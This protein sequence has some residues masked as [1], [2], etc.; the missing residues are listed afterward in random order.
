MTIYVFEEDSMEKRYES[1]MTRKEKRQN[2]LKKLKSMTF[3]QKVGYIW[4]YYKGVFAGIII[5]CVIISIGVQMF[6]NS[7]LKSL[8]SIAV[9]DSNYNHDE[10]VEAL[11]NDFLAYAGTGDKHEVVDVDTGRAWRWPGQLWHAAGFI[12]TILYGLLG[13]SYD[14]VVKMTVVMGAG[15]ADMMFCGEETYKKY[16]QQE[17][18][19]SWKEILG[20][21]YSKYEEY[22]TDDG[23]LDL[24][25][26]PNWEKYNMVYYSPV[27]AVVMSSS[28]NLENCIKFLE[29]MVQ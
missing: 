25:K 14:E 5:A 4:T 23:R 2:E 6:Q 15:T 26:C 18:F 16:K 13:I 29:M 10:Q 12:S 24:E 27:Y 22:M 28:K 21:D 7:Q 19:L 1:D 9:V 17:A 20:D 8:L 3:K 11:Q